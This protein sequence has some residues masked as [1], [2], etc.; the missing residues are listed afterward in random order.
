MNSIVQMPNRTLWTGAILLVMALATMSAEAQTTLHVANIGVDSGTCGGSA[1]PCRSI[2]RAIARARDGDIILVSPG[3]YGDLDRDGVLGGPG[4]EVGPASCQCMIHVNKRVTLVSRSGALQTV[5]DSGTGALLDYVIQIT[6]SNA[7]LG[8]P[9]GGFTV[10]GNALIGV[11]VEAGAGVAVIGNVVDSIRGEGLFDA[12]RGGGISLAQGEAHRVESN[13]VAHH[14]NGITVTTSRSR[15]T[16][17]FAHDN[18]LR[19]IIVAAGDRTLVERN[20]STHNLVGIEV[21]GTNHLVRRNSVVGNFG[22]GVAVENGNIIPTSGI[23][24]LENNI[25]GNATSVVG[26]VEPNCGLSNRT[27]RGEVNARN[28]FWGLASGPGVDPADA[29]CNPGGTGTLLTRPFATSEIAIP[30]GAAG[31]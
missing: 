3:Q 27:F 19:G 12:N 28:N 11:R 10:H 25:F 16:A 30:T 5:V 4:E 6:A 24:V 29:A 1:E 18:A 9:L 17:N 23:H 14:A 13:V 15:V 22:V 31:S 2:T 21:V 7:V 8:G 26:G 20:V